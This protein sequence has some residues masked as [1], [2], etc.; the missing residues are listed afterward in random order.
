MATVTPRVRVP[1]SGAAPRAGWVRHHPLAAF[2]L[3]CFG[4][5][6]AALIP[7][8]ADS[9]GWL[10]LNIPSW[11]VLPLAGW[12]PGLAAFSVAAAG[13]RGRVLLARLTTWRLG[14][15]WYAVALLAPGVLYAAAL[16]LSTLLAGR[17]PGLPGLG[18]PLLS[19]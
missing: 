3:L 5:T 17:P 8:A 13:G 2:L 11:L 6:W 15:N 14:L 7:A 18:L 12:G 9:R 10:P 19:G 4:L 1:A 16:A